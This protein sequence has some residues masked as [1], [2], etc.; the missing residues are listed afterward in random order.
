MGEKG[1]KLCAGV[2]VDACR[3]SGLPRSLSAATKSSVWL[4]SG[5]SSR[6]CE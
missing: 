3:R 2:C 1:M 5:S 6:L 4:S